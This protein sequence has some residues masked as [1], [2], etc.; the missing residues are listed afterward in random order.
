M[1]DSDRHYL[2]K[3]ALDP[4]TENGVE[5]LYGFD[6]SY[7]FSCDDKIDSYDGENIPDTEDDLM[8]DDSL[9]EN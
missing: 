1:H 4:E 3:F 9:S 6:F 2:S 5:D 8:E 7:N